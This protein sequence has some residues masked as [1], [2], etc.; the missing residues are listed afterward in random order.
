MIHNYSKNEGSSGSTIIS[1]YSNASIIG[2]HFGSLD[3]R[4]NLSI[5]IISIFS[6]IN[7]NYII[8]EFEIKEEDKNKEILIIN[9]FEQNKRKYNLENKED[10]C[11]YENEKEIKQNCEIKIN[12]NIIP[13]SYFYIFKEKGIYQIQYS[14]KK[15]LSKTCYMFIDCESL[16]NIDLS[17]F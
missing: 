13:F 6:D 9:S 2:L 3:D 7:K 10:D 5:D 1:R 17:I 8:A 15:K 16:I 12:G 4:I 11:K 14:F